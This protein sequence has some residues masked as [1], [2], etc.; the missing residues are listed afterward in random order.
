MYFGVQFLYGLVFVVFFNVVFKKGVENKFEKDLEWYFCFYV[1]EN[2]F[3]M[4]FSYVNLS[5]VGCLDLGSILLMLI[6]GI[7][8]FDLE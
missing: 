5:G 7:L 1:Y 8:E 2:I 4:G 6:V 3:L